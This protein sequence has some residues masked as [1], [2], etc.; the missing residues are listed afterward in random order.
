MAHHNQNALARNIMFYTIAKTAMLTGAVI[1]SGVIS[2]I[3]I[4]LISGQFVF[5]R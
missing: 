2:I 3:G 5:Q 1:L 4:A